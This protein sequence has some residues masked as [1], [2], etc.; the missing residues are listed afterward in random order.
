MT[1]CTSSATTSEV[2]LS[3]SVNGPQRHLRL[4][5]TARKLGHFSSRVCEGPFLMRR[6]TAWIGLL[7][8]CS[9]QKWSIFIE[10]MNLTYVSFQ[11]QSNACG[12]SAVVRSSVS[13]QMALCFRN[14]QNFGHFDLRNIATSS[15]VRIGGEK[16]ST[17]P[18]RALLN[19]YRLERGAAI[20]HSPT[21]AII[22]RRTLLGL[23][24]SAGTRSGYGESK[25]CILRR[26][27]LWMHRQEWR[28]L[29]SRGSVKSSIYLQPAEREHF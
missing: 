13:S 4:S 20:S 17:N 5:T 9:S 28:S 1:R 26:K 25:D 6:C 11:M 16:N 7:N 27:Q 2:D 19:S 10:T 22:P 15:C 24:P 14:A 18:I 29:I 8:P 3:Q 12:V 23:V 21:L